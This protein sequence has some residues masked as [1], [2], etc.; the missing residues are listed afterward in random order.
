MFLLPINVRRP[1]F[2]LDQA[3]SPPPKPYFHFNFNF[4]L[5]IPPTFL[6]ITQIPPTVF[7]QLSFHVTSSV[8]PCPPKRSAPPRMSNA[9]PCP[10][11]KQSIHHFIGTLMSTLRF[12]APW[13]DFEGRSFRPSGGLFLASDL[14]VNGMYKYR[15]LPPH[16]NSRFSLSARV[17]TPPSSRAPAPL[18]RIH[19][20]SNKVHVGPCALHSIRSRCETF[21]SCGLFLFLIRG[22]ITFAAIHR[23]IPARNRLPA[24][25]SC[26]PTR[27]WIHCFD[28]PL[29]TAS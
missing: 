17:P 14:S 7:L 23:Q 26:S 2:Q 3:H 8:S 16:R 28:L 9:H 10:P 22:E 4:Y 21:P 20:Q 11:G 6:E 24:G 13:P 18:S 19:Q 29:I 12:H 5:S 27:T 1:L 25:H 15:A